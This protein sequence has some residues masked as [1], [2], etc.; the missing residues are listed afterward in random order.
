MSD[1]SSKFTREDLETLLEAMGEWEMVGNHEFHIL[2]LIKSAPMPPDDHEA[3]ESMLAIKEH[4]KKREREIKLSRETKQEKAVFLKAKLMLVR[5]DLG[6]N[7]LFDMAVHTD[8]NSP[9]PE[10]L[11]RAEEPK[12]VLPTKRKKREVT[13]TAAPTQKQLELAEFFIKD[14]GV[15]EHYQKFLIERT[16]VTPTSDT[17]NSSN[18]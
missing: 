6:I 2:Q 9:M 1:L 4:F 15:W 13:S 18:N 17:D 14:L 12:A 10:V 11:P 7:Q 8:P 3:Y 16:S 5:R